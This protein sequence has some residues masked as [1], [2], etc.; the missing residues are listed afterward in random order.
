M[1]KH[2][3]YISSKQAVVANL[4]KAETTL[5]KYIYNYDSSRKSECQHCK[6]QHGDGS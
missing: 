5:I 3:L 2:L 4:Y 1:Y 6:W